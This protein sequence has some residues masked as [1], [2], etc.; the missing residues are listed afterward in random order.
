MSGNEKGILRRLWRGL[1]DLLPT[2]GIGDEGPAPDIDGRRD[3]DSDYR[4]AVLAAK[5]Q[6]SSGGQATTS[7]EPVDRS[8]LHDE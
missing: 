4:R 7:Y 2:G 5:S 8:R 6:M 3:T 1:T